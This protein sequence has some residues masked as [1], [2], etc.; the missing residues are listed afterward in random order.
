MA[1]IRCR[2]WP[3]SKIAFCGTSDDCD[4]AGSAILD[5]AASS[6]LHGHGFSVYIERPSLQVE[7]AN[8]ALAGDHVAITQ[9]E[10]APSNV[11]AAGQ[12]QI[13]VAVRSDAGHGNGFGCGRRRQ[14]AHRRGCSRRLCGVA[15]C[16]ASSR[17]GAVMAQAAAACIAALLLAAYLRSCGYHASGKL[18]V[19]RRT[20]DSIYVPVRKHAGV[21]RRADIDRGCGAGTTQPDLTFKSCF[22]TKSRQTLP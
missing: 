15:D 13:Q 4:K 1:R 17:E 22:Q 18:F 21:S 7:E 5:A 2:P 14:S 3:R 8:A 16:R 6:Y 19:C 12:E 9:G 10:D 20:F 11:N